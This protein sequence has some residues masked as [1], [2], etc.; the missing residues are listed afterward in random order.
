M[1][2]ILEIFQVRLLQVKVVRMLLIFGLLTCFASKSFGMDE[3]AGGQ[4][5]SKETRTYGKMEVKMWAERRTGTTSTFYW[6]RE[7]GTNCGTDWNEIDIETLSGR[8]QYQSNALWQINN[9]PACDYPYK[10]E[11]WHS[12]AASIF[13]RWVVYTLEWSPGVIKWY[14]DGILDRT[15]TGTAANTIA[16]PMKYCFNLWSQGPSSSWLGNL[17]MTLLGNDPVFQFV[18]Y[19]KYYAWTGTGFSGT[20][21]KTINFDSYADL[22]ANFNISNWE[23]HAQSNNYVFWRP[24]AV[25]VV[26]L[27]NGNSGLWLGL[28]LNGKQRSPAGAEIPGSSSSPVLT[29]ITV[30][31][32]TSTLTVGQTQQFTAAGKDQN[33]N[34]MTM[35][36]TWTTTGGGTISTSGLFTATT[37]GGPFTVK[38]TSGTVSGLAS[39]TVNAPV[40]VTAIPGKV[41]AENYS[42]YNNAQPTQMRVATTD[43]GTKMGYNDAGDWYD[44]SVNVQTAGTYTVTFRVAN[45]ATAAGQFQLLKGTTVLSTVDVAPTGGWENF[46]T[47]TKTVSLTTTGIQTIRI[48]TVTAG[49]DYNWF[50]F[51]QAVATSYVIQAENYTG[52]FGIQTET[53]TDAGGGLNVGWIDAGDWMTYSVNIATAGTYNVNFRLAGWANT[54]RISLQNAA[55]TTLTSANVPNGGATAYQVWSTVHGESTFTLAAGTQ[56]IRIYATGSPWNLNW[57]E[58]YSGALKSAQ[59]ET[60]IANSLDNKISI[61]PNPASN[62]LYIE[63][64]VNKANVSIFDLSGKLVIQKLLETGINKI[65]IS[66]LNSGLFLINVNGNI[67]KFVKK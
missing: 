8:G 37:A 62:I 57:F 61:Y 6:W 4:I 66:D 32:A 34:A 24:D 12:D 17:D 67:S 20:P 47:L 54:G 60:S 33:G 14:H 49:V 36:P 26:S 39:V 59:I 3:L 29:T 15:L 41:E 52:M 7:G 51:T 64:P 1:S 43:G 5:M 58:I 22:T 44:Y 31:P 2:K 55:N 45:G 23:F 63:N 21:T 18:D 30:T 10:S 48:N 40:T 28:F 11:G 56:T 9:Q 16:N 46:V 27:G 13:G 53:T 25:G 65:N 35:T 50:Q 19:L 38:A 42:A